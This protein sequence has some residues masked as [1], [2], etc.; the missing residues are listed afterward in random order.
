MPGLVDKMSILEKIS[1]PNQLKK[2][3]KAELEDLAKEIRQILVKTV[4]AT[5]GHLAS[6]LGVVELTL[7]LLAILEVP[8]DKIIWDVG[9]QCYSHKIL[10]GR[11]DRIS[12]IR[13]FEGIS[14][15]PRVSES[16]HDAFSVGHASTALSAALGMA[17]ARDLKKE[18]F[19]VVAV[20]G[21]GSLSGGLTFEALNNI[22]S[23]KTKVT[24][25]LNDNGMSIS[26][27]TG[28][29]SK[30]ITQI[31]TSRLYNNVRTNT[32]RLFSKIPKIGQPLYKRIEYLVDRS[33]HL[34]VDL[35]FGV[36]FEE[37]GFKYLGPIDGH[38]IPLL[39]G[40]IRFAKSQKEPV[41]IHI[42]TKK[43]KGYGPAEGDPT[44]FHGIGAFFVKT[45]ESKKEKVTTYTEV[46]ADTLV[47]LAQKNK[48]IVAITAAMS[49]GTG[50]VNFAAKFPGRFFDVGIAEEHAV[51][52]AAGLANQGLIPFVAIYSTFLQRAYDQLIH[53]VCLDNYPVIFCL[54]RSGLVGPDGPTHHGLFDLCYLRS[55]PNLTVMAPK[56]GNELR[57]MMNLALE[58][59]GPVA[60]RY[61]KAKIPD[62]I[63]NGISLFKLGEAEVVY[64]S[65]Q[66]EKAPAEK[67]IAIVAIGS[68]VYPSVA[69]ARILEE[70]GRAKCVVVNAR[71]LK[72]LDEKLLLDLAS[73]FG[74]IFTVEEGV[75]AGGFGTGI[76]EFY[77]SQNLC[78]NIKC[79][80]LP[81]EFITQGENSVLLEKYGLAPEGIASQISKLL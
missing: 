44:R 75:L 15:F 81:D 57:A 64:Q 22:G 53:D 56:D 79:L 49:E 19:E 62:E 41:I 52:F 36:I 55:I 48:K 31:R 32:E 7:A 63:K 76:L 69:G 58:I 35:K 6:S 80:G 27:A 47:E 50:L 34:L 77:S 46:F 74:Q 51:T 72:P 30:Y 9:H 68:M 3:T 24:V 70:N 23:L 33:K 14:G 28:A 45:G 10:T 26:P 29:I 16:E 78:P 65:E 38:N 71:F 20:L 43:G 12:T 37:F 42:L 59:K 25:I 1:E 40:A 21:D 60:I 66:I 61:P 13:K 4:S 73:N 67:R 11:L 2:L 18:N 8:R 5:G 39:M 17:K 54:D